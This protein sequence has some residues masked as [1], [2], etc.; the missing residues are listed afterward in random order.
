MKIFCDLRPHLP[1]IRPSKDCPNWL[2]DFDCTQIYSLA[3]ADIRLSFW[4]DRLR[5][6][7]AALLPDKRDIC[8]V[9]S[10]LFN[11]SFI[12]SA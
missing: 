12:I 7:P 8:D 6:T 5:L 9:A 10:L 2:E 11:K 1:L 3:L 4:E